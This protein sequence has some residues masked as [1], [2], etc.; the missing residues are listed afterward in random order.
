MNSTRRHW[1]ST[2]L[3]IAAWPEVLA[4]RQHAHTV[5]GSPTPHFE[6]LDANTAAEIEAIAAQII[7][8]T[9]GPGAREAGVVYFIDRAL[10]TF[11]IDDREA[12]RTGMAQ[13]QEKR[14]EL[15]P[16]STTITSLTGQQQI[17]LIRSIETFSFF[18]LLRTHTV[19]G[20]LGNPSY[21]GNREKVGW[22]A[23]GLED[24]M[25]HQPPFGYYDA[26]IDG[27]KKWPA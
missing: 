22:H 23:I 18:E 13:V 10:S 5:A 19:L 9:E 11:A 25:G 27:E 16:N 4:A 14:K 3:A 7:P 12:Y 24:R 15:F 8:S 21:G 17:T 6:T 2:C 20:F 1:F 26:Q